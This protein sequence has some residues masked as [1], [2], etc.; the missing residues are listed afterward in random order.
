MVCTPKDHTN[1]SWQIVSGFGWTRHQTINLPTFSEFLGSWNIFSFF[2]VP[3]PNS[4]LC[5]TL[6]FPIR[7]LQMQIKQIQCTC[8]TYCTYCAHCALYMLHILYIYILCIL[9]ILYILYIL[10]MLWNE[11]KSKGWTW[12]LLDAF[13][14]R[15][16]LDRTLGGRTPQYTS[17][18]G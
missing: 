14:S 8:F 3:G 5:C 10:Y 1:P 12:M 16:P 6:I 4:F 9:R 7:F 11:D 17:T 13:V 2:F 15:W 18:V